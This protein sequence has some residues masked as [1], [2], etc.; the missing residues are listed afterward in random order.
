MSEEID[1]VVSSS[2]SNPKQAVVIVISGRLDKKEAEQL[3]LDLRNLIS[4]Y[5]KLTIEIKPK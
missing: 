4:K 5:K 3:R 1:G 2:S